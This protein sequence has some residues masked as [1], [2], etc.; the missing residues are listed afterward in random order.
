MDGS[1]WPPV[2]FVTGLID[3]ASILGLGRIFTANMTGNVVFLG[4]AL[5]GGQDLSIAA[6]LIALGGFLAGAGLRFSRLRQAAGRSCCLG[7]ARDLLPSAGCRVARL[8]PR[9]GRHV[10]AIR[11][12]LVA[13]GCA[14]FSAASYS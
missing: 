5:G 6:S 4:F 11:C 10:G 14:L 8:S 3:A 1:L 13:I 9:C 7:G 12:T 2:T